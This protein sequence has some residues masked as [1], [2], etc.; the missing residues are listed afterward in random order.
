MLL[1]FDNCNEYC[2]CQSYSGRGVREL[3]SFDGIFRH[4]H[5]VGECWLGTMAPHLVLQTLIDRPLKADSKA[6]SAS[7]S[8]WR[9]SKGVTGIGDPA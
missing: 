5:C 7:R 1:D 3:R 2:E 4:R 9:P 6:Q 8:A